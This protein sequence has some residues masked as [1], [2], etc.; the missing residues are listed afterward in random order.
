M[1]KYVLGFMMGPSKWNVALIKKKRPKWQAGKYNGIGGHIEKGEKPYDAMVR[2][3]EEETGYKES[4]WRMFCIL[5]GDD[6]KVYCYAAWT[7]PKLESK[8]DEEVGWYSLDDLRVMPIIPNLKW[9]IPLA[10][11][12]QVVAHVYDGIPMEDP[13]A[14]AKSLIKKMLDNLEFKL[15]Q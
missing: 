9:L 7:M 4:D 10:R 6:W 3:F 11:D 15:D 8:T 14:E 1:K 2:E 13:K 12:S 5:H